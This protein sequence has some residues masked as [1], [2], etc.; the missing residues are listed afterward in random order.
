MPRKNIIVGNTRGTGNRTGQES[1]E[2]VADAGEEPQ[3]KNPI[4]SIIKHWPPAWAQVDE[5]KANGVST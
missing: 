1:I 2:T 4:F 3:F 5:I